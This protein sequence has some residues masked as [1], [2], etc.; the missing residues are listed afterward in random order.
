MNTNDLPV[1]EKL[2]ALIEAG[3]MSNPG[4]KHGD[5]RLMRG[6]SAC[7]MGYALLAIGATDLD[8]R[9]LQ[10]YG[11][12]D[13]A[14]ILGVSESEARALARRVACM[15][16]KGAELKDIIEAIRMDTL[17]KFPVSAFDHIQ[18]D[19]LY[20][21]IPLKTIYVHP[22]P[23]QTF[24]SVGVEIGSWDEVKAPKLTVSTIK[25]NPRPEPA[26]AVRKS[27]KTG[28]T[29]PKPKHAYA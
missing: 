19:A 10:D 1:A 4:I 11:E 2:A 26:K 21:I 3:S 24:Y 25:G 13:L 15:N 17:P 20:D 22:L 6:N 12:K 23:M 9:S 16:D 8:K 14:P 27:A 7:A 28:A 18:W 5:G 29:W